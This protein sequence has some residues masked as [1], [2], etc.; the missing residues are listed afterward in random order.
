M[1]RSAALFLALLAAASASSASA[2]GEWTPFEARR[3]ATGCLYTWTLTSRFGHALA[4]AEALFGPRDP[5]WTPLG[6]EF[7]DQ[8]APQVWYPRFG[9]ADRFIAVQL[10]R[11]AARDETE[12]LF[13]LAHEAVHVIAPIGPDVVAS[14]FEEGLATWFSLRYLVEDGRGLTP[15]YIAS[16]RYRAAFNDVAALAAAHPGDA[17]ASGVRRLRALAGAFSPV[18]P[19]QLRSAFPE[20]TPALAE[21]LAREHPAAD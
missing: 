9:S 11:S 16:R 3:C 14:R 2:K 5:S 7:S 1:T 15:D 8:P 4:R 17:F 21:A 20:A 10:T 6:V 19:S 13:Q 12:A 18:T